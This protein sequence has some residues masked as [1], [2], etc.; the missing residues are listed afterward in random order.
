M[1]IFVCHYYL[2]IIY[3]SPECSIDLR[4]VFLHYLMHSEKVFL[5]TFVD[6]IYSQVHSG[7]DV[8]FFLFSVDLVM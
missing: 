4:V 8:N 5:I 2:Y 7:A 1:F 3:L 6:V